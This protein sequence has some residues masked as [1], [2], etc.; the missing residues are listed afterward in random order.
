MRRSCAWAAALGTQELRLA[1]P[2]VLVKT[3]LPD[4]LELKITDPD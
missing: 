2:R 4:F 3:L 1:L